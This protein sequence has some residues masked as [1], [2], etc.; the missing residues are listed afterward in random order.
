MMLDCGKQVTVDQ[1][2]NSEG[3]EGGYNLCRT[4]AVQRPSNHSQLH[5][6]GQLPSLAFY[7]TSGRV[8][9]NIHG[10]SS[11]RSGDLFQFNL[12]NNNGGLLFRGMHVV[13][14]S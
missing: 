9:R 10:I 3:K 13:I 7:E 11:L 14:R 6:F 12:K 2:F 4:I 1:S 5:L 8:L